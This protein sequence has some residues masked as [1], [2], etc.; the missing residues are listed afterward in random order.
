HE[1][2][3]QTRR[4]LLTSPRVNAPVRRPLQAMFAVAALALSATARGEV[5]PVV[6]TYEPDAGCPE[7]GFFLDAVR[8][9][10]SNVHAP[11]PPGRA[12]TD[13]APLEPPGGGASAGPAPQQ[14]RRRPG[15]RRAPPG[16]Q[17]ARGSSPPPRWPR[18]WPSTPPPPAPRRRAPPQKRLAQN[19]RRSP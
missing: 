1:S 15:V 8:S 3:F 14:K 12:R 18:R 5:A 4:G 16:A 6:I 2:F 7:E 9:Q 10:T 17:A 13:P 19:P 11:A